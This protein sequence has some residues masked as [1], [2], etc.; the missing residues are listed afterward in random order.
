MTRIL[1]CV[2]C[3][4]APTYASWCDA[5]TP[6]PR[7][8]DDRPLPGG[9]CNARYGVVERGAGASRRGRELMGVDER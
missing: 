9:V 4:D 8:D 6:G 7:V 1:R 5:A 3:G 2:Y